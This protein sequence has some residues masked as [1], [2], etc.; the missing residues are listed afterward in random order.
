MGRLA[1]LMNEYFCRL[2]PMLVQMEP[3]TLTIT[4]TYQSEDVVDWLESW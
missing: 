1:S 2:T 4:P 3:T